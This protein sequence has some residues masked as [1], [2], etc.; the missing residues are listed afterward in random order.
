MK[1]I[2]K[3]SFIILIINTLLKYKRNIKDD[4]NDTFETKGG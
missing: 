2:K 1:P 3:H 4:N